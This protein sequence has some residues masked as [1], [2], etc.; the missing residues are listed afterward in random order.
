MFGL[1]NAIFSVMY[2]IVY[3][4]KLFILLQLMFFTLKSL[5]LD[6]NLGIPAYFVY[7]FLTAKNQKL[8]DSRPQ[9]FVVS[10]F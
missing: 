6:D 5:L 9:K 8:E 7:E 3:P 4:H 10:Q 1:S 2:S